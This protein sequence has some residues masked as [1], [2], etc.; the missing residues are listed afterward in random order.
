LRFKCTLIIIKL[1]YGLGI[2]SEKLCSLT[3]ELKGQNDISKIV[4]FYSNND[5]RNIFNPFEFR[6]VLYETE[7]KYV[8]YDI[9]DRFYSK[10]KVLRAQTLGLYITSCGIGISALLYSFPGTYLI[11]PSFILGTVAFSNFRLK[12]LQK[13][14]I[15]HYESIAQE[16]MEKLNV[17]YS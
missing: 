7:A 4:L 15:D 1:S 11:A 14:F 13:S 12:R 8:D 16:T 6:K 2:I 10:S 5:I 3:T 9:I 17:N